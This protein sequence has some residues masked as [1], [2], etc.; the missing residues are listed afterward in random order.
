M[1]DFNRWEKFKELGSGGQSTVYLA[2]NPTRSQE[3]GLAVVQLQMLADGAKHEELLRLGYELNR[4]ELPE[5]LGALKIFKIRPG[6]GAPVERLKREVEI[7]KQNRPN[8][9]RLLD[10]NVDAGEPW[11]ITEYFP[12]G[13]LAEER[14]WRKYI[15]EPLEALKAFRGLVKTIAELHRAEIVHRDIKPENVFIAADGSL[16]PG[17][18]GLVWFKNASRLT[19]ANE[20]IGPWEHLPRWANM[21]TRFDNPTAAIDV[22]LLG[23]L[24]WCMVSGHHR[25]H[26]DWYKHDEFNLEKQFPDNKEIPL[27]NLVLSQCLGAE[28]KLCVPTASDVLNVVDEVVAAITDRAPLFDENDILVIPCPICR[29]GFYKRKIGPEGPFTSTLT[30]FKNNYPA[31]SFT[32]EPYEC[33]LCQNIVNFQAHFPHSGLQRAR[34]PRVN[35]QQITESTL[36]W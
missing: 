30:F 24:L 16:I 14:N 29:K 31:A 15:G 25:L 12:N 22:Y 4:P 18:F 11:M 34:K 19:L 23:S 2:R 5:E 8:L 6:S 9:P 35:P 36:R 21:G 3:R 17:D 28:E 13:T 1:S 10:S 27:V 26:G 20:T 32:L 7:L 33:D